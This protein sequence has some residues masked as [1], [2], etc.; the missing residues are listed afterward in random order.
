MAH[1]FEGAKYRETADLA[2]KDITKLIRKDIQAA[3]AKGT[4]PKGKYSVV[5]PH[6]GAIRIMVKQIDLP[7][8]VTTLSAEDRTRFST[9]NT[10][11]F[12]PK[13][14]A[15]IETLTAMANEYLYDDTDIMTDY[16]NSRFYLNVCFDFALE[17]LKT[18]YGNERPTS[19]FERV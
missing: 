17:V 4:L 2:L 8:L 1:K 6:W 12:T 13:A 11:S 10:R 7:V 5:I 16:F 19:I 15:V 14:K 3:I 9:P 18:Q